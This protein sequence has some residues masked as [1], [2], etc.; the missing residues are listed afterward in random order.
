MIH[1]PQ[2]QSLSFPHQYAIYIDTQDKD[3]EILSRNSLTKTLSGK[4]NI[5]GS[6]LWCGIGADGRTV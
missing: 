5:S 2:P 4:K 3:L 6:L 1:N